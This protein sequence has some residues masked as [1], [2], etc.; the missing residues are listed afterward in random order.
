MIQMLELVKKD[1]KTVPTYIRMKIT[2]IT[3]LSEGYFIFA[4]DNFKTTERKFSVLL[5]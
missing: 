5:Q 4:S 3:L 1:L 2:E